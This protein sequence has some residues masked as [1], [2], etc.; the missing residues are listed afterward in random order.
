MSAD[1]TVRDIHK[2]FG[3]KEILTG[4][5]FE[6]EHGGILAIIGPSGSGKTTLLRC[7]NAL[8]TPDS[9]TVTIGDRVLD[10]GSHPRHRDILALRRRTAMVF[11]DYNLFRNK[12]AIDNVSEGLVVV[13]GKD[14]KVAKDE[15]LA[16]LDQVGLADFADRYPAQL[17][18]GQQQRVSIARALALRPDVILFD[19]PTS[20]LDPE[21]VGDVLEAIK[22]IAS[23]GVTMILVT[24]EIRFARHVAS[25]VIFMD[26]GAIVEQGPPAAVIDH[27]ANDRTR[28]FLRRIDEK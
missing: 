1:C 13:Q 24:H 12:T 11:Q 23:E 2:S 25:D 21:L 28:D 8:E 14:R 19:E 3:E 26:A 4:V 22:D 10:Y 17:S 20:A 18:G 5:S 16:R 7:I 27:P 6:V 9:G 15:A